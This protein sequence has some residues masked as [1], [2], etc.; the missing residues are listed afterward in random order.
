MAAN[1]HLALVPTF[2]AEFP[3]FLSEFESKPPFRL[4]RWGSDDGEEGA[5]LGSTRLA[6]WKLNAPGGESFLRALGLRVK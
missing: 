1:S 2:I 6:Y 4:V 5:L 3:R